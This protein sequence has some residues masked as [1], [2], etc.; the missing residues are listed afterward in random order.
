MD[1]TFARMIVPRLERFNDL[2]VCHPVDLTMEEWTTI[3]D[4]MIAGFKFYASEDARF[5]AVG[6]EFDRAQVGIDLFAKWYPHLWW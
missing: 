1:G 6:D 5:E 4:E 2:K 3:I